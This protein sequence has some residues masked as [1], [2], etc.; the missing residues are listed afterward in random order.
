MNKVYAASYY[1]SFNYGAYD[2]YEYV[3]IASSE[4]EALGY[5]LQYEAKTEADFWSFEEVDVQHCGAH[6]ISSRSV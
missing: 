3:I 1:R 2:E 6:Y 5:A 4:S